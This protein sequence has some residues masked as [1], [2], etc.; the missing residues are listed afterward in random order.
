MIRPDSPTAHRIAAENAHTGVLRG[1]LLTCL[2]AADRLAGPARDRFRA[3]VGHAGMRLDVGG[4]GIHH[5][6][7]HAQ[8]R[9]FVFSPTGPLALILPVRSVPNDRGAPLLDLAAW[10]PRTGEVFCRL[11]ATDLLGEWAAWP[12][13]D[14]P[15]TVFADPGAWARA[16]GDGVFLLTWGKAWNLLHHLTALVAPTVEFGRRLDAAMQ[17]P[18]QRRPQIYVREEAVAA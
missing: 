4:V 2:E 5:I 15:V 9:T 17:P 10:L 11:G 12:A 13:T 1:E 6:T 7:P 18:P 8:S 3:L 14:S 16:N